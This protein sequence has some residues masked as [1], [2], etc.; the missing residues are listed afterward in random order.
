MHSAFQVNE[1]IRAY[2]LAQSYIEELQ[3]F[4]EDAN[5]KMSL[6]LEPPPIL[7]AS[8]PSAPLSLM[9]PAAAANGH[10][11]EGSR[12]GISAVARVSAAT[13][14]KTSPL[15]V[16]LSLS[17]REQA[18]RKKT[19]PSA[20]QPLSFKMTAVALEKAA[21]GG[22][23]EVEAEVDAEGEET[24]VLCTKSIKTGTA[25]K[26]S[27]PPNPVGLLESGGCAL[28]LATVSIDSK[29]CFA[30]DTPV[31]KAKKVVI[32][33]FFLSRCAINLHFEHQNAKFR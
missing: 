21:M 32:S 30:N 5:F 14:C 29:T 8:S 20:V 27:L 13:S 12:R 2:L 23:A 15:V 4:L 24:E 33:L 17:D 18:P 9:A 25:V 31:S 16:A 7:D 10:S 3:K 19:L 11:T 22:G 6:H 1:S 28:N 26:L